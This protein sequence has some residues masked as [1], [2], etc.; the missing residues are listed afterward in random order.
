MPANCPACD[1]PM[2]YSGFV[3]FPKQTIYFCAPCREHHFFPE[4]VP[5]TAPVT[6]VQPQ[7]Q[8]QAKLEP[9][10]KDDDT[11]P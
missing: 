10:Q 5:S 2:K 1:S 4:S 3:S 6:Q 8:P 7:Q 11:Q 9:E